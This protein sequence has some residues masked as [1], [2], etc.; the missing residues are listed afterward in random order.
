MLGPDSHQ[1]AIH[2]GN[3]IL[4]ESLPRDAFPA[5]VV[6]LIFKPFAS[7]RL[8]AELTLGPTKKLLQVAKLP[9]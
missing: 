4:T 1:I 3:E 6:G 2:V 7:D 8:L 5:P 9:V